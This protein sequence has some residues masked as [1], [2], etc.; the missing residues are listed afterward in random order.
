MHTK[1]IVSSV[2]TVLVVGVVIGAACNVAILS[3][4]LMF[5][6]RITAKTNVLNVSA[7]SRLAIKCWCFPRNRKKVKVERNVCG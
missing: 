5:H 1:F 2:V 3:I 4:V 6:L 7:A